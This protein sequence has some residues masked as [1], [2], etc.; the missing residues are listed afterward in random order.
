ML[1]A[2]IRILEKKNL[3]LS[4]EKAES[5]GA[6]SLGAAAALLS[7]FVGDS[8]AKKLIMIEWLAGV[9]AEA[10]RHGSAAHRTVVLVLSRD[11][12]SVYTALWKTLELFA[13]K[14]LH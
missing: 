10:I 7:D 12:E 2:L 5:P 4:D 6:N 3:S 1:Y 11:G 9:S 14:T 8:P 13:D